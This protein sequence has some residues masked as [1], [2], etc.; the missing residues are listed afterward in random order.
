MTHR[1]Y[2]EEALK[3][4]LSCMGATSPNPPV[5]AVIV[6][7]GEVLS[8]GRT[9]PYGSAHAEVAALRAAGKDLRGAEMYVSLEP[10]CHRGKTPPCTDAIIRAGIARVHIPVLD[11]NPLVAGKGLLALR[12]AGVDVVLQRDAAPAAS[13][14]I[15]PFKKYILRKRPFTLLKLAMTLDGHTATASGDSQWISNPYSRYYVHRL[16]SLCDAVV[17]G[18]NTLELDNPSLTVRYDEFPDEVLQAFNVDGFTLEGYDNY[19]VR[20][21]LGP[22]EGLFGAREPLRIAFGLPDGMEGAHFFRTDK[23]LIL[24]SEERREAL[25]RDNSGSSRIR[26]DQEEGRICFLPGETPV[27]RVLAAQ[28]ELARRGLMFI[29]LEGGGTLAGAFNDAGEI[30]QYMFV[31]APKISGGGR[32]A[33]SGRGAGLMRESRILTNVSTARLKG[34]LLYC[35]Y[36]EDYNFEMM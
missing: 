3:L 31:I 5:G 35:G 16:R 12:S 13:D 22:G 4:A 34:D 25:L 11:P 26:R 30:D 6:M 9:G 20:S 29:L 24:E 15:R 14:L 19:P 21:L 2:M 32:G 33:V 8:R 28:E 7:G 23:Y 36:K 17:V 18:R 27:E 10:C 1:V